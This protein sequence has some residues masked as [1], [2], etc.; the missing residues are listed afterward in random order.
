MSGRVQ[1]FLIAST[2]FLV[3]GSA[4]GAQPEQWLQYHCANEAPR[5]A[6]DMG[7]ATPRPAPGRPEGIELPSFQ[8]ETPLFA[9][10]ETPVVEAGG[11]WLAFDRLNK[12]GRYDLLHIDSNGDGNLAKE[13]PYQ[14]YRQDE[15]YTYFGPVRSYIG[16]YL[17]FNDYQTDD[18]VG[19]AFCKVVYRF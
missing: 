16:L 4:A 14:S 10:W 7:S 8:C 17:L 19:S 15:H 2:C 6:G 18:E 11:L 9:R 3:W 1:V 5:I 12:R 13:S